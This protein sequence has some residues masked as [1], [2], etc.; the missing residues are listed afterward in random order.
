MKTI[1]QTLIGQTILIVDG[2]SVAAAELADRLTT[3][4][5][6]V[7]VVANAACGARFV[8]AKKF[9][10][11]LIG[12]DH[13]ELERG[14]FRELEKRHVPYVLCASTSKFGTIPYERVFSLPLTGAIAA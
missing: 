4:G 5:A 7:H 11:A 13:A 6:K 2:V 9:D 10:I 3:L 8:A 14:L 12:Y 1:L